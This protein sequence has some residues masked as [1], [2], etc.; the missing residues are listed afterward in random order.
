M[1]ASPR[2]LADAQILHRQGKLSEA[3]SLYLH[4]LNNHPA[5]TEGLQLLGL[6]HADTGRLETGLQLLRAA[7]GIEGPSPHLCR[8]LG[9]LLDRK[10]DRAAAIACFRQALA[11]APKDW[12]LWRAL[13]ML[14]AAEGRHGEAASSWQ[15]VVE[16]GAGARSQQAAARCC[17]ADQLLLAGKRGY[18]VEQYQRAVRIDPES[19]TAQFHL[20][21]AL[22]QSDLGAEAVCAF[23]TTLALDPGHAEA[24][25]NLAILLQLAGQMPEAISHYRQAIQSSRGYEGALYN[26]GTALQ[27]DGQTGKA[28][29]VFRKLLK[30][31]PRHTAG[32][33]HLGNCRLARNEVGLARQ[34]YYESLAI[35]PGEKAA[36]W[37][38]GLAHLLEGDYTAGWNGYEAR[39][40]VQGATP[41]RV[42][43][44]PVWRGE[45]LEGKSILFHAE[46][47]LG[48]SLQFVR[49]APV[50]ASMGATVHVE[51]QPSLLPLLRQMDGVA[52]WHESVP[53]PAGRLEAA[54][55]NRLPACDYQ[56]PFLSA[57]AVLGTKPETIPSP[58]G[59]L[60]APVFS[61]ETWRN[62]LGDPRQRFRAGLVWGGNPNHKNDRNRSLDASLLPAWTHNVASAAPVDWINLQK[63][64]PAP[65]GVNFLA[66]PEPGD[67][68]DTA[69]LIENLDVVITVDTSVAHLAGALGK[70]VWILLPFAPDWRWM[71]QRSDSPW[72]RSAQ[73]FRQQAPGNWTGV[74]RQVADALREAAIM[75][76]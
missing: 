47:G 23:R 20:G 44:S 9:I 29:T 39:F 1:T 24:H 50:L 57:P 74:L 18:A 6:L 67:F 12:E 8:N 41:R 63:G 15:R 21:V 76:H 5:D 64:R 19:V 42:F 25:N 26:L 58:E 71:L 66:L 3:E 62:R 10:G 55:V 68:S 48:D 51:C 56:L 11:A 28:M 69:G 40:E 4:H 46:Q 22:M 27:E 43:A 7:I 38:L 59:Y 75:K 49:F 17:W 33:T 2:L 70:P 16:G 14:Q 32:W 52:A 61:K 37:N 73:L 34:A 13:A 31:Q 72:Y 60:Q 54:P 30:L 53:V 45:H 36:A 35:D 65:A